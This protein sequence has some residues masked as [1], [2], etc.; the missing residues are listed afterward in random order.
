MPVRDRKLPRPKTIQVS[1]DEDTLT[2]EY[3]RAFFSLKN[4][5]A[6]DDGHP[7]PIEQALVILPKIILKWD[8]LDQRGKTHPITRE[9]LEEQF[10]VHELVDLQN[11]VF[12]DYFPNAT[13]SGDSSV[14]GSSTTARGATALDGISTSE[15]PTGSTADPGS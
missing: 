8:L 3:D 5:R 11:A 1:L 15:L 4:V 12:T 7:D 9:T 13:R 2:L 6:Q 14:S 10:G